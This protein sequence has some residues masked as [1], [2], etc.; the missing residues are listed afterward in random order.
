[1]NE[2]L[3]QP[4]LWEP[5]VDDVPH[6][7]PSDPG[8]SWAAARATEREEGE[9]SELRPGS[10]KHLALSRIVE[11]PSTALEVERVTGRRG[12]WKRVSDLKNAALI[13][14]AGT[15][16][17]PET[18]RDGIVWAATERGRTVQMLLDRGQA[19]K[20]RHEAVAA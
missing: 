11:R 12:I 16:R 9:T 13:E 20:L 2:L 14:P 15:R 8:T 17:D 1:M 3:D 19:V 10:A 18:N 4:T 5:E 6:A 7:R